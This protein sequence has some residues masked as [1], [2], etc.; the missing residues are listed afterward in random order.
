MNSDAQAL[1]WGLTFR[2]LVAVLF[3]VAAVFWPGLTLLTLLYLFSTWVLVEGVVRLVT[4]INRMTASP[5]SFL[6]VVV[7][8][9]QVGVGI[10]LLRHPAV[11]FATFILLIGFT[12]IVSGVVEVVSTLSSGDTMTGRTLAALVGLAAAVAGIL[13]LFQ[14]EK[15]GVAF[16][17]ILGLYALI[18]GPVMLAMSMDV[19]KM[20]EGGGRRR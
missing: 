17:W 13:M 9:F 11:S 2:G 5:L 12:L 10:Y 14:P 8:L 3:G 6:T 15:S 4:G 16:V 7:G 20:A 18:T 1:W 19:R